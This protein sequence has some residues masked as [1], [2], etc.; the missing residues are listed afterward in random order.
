MTARALVCRILP[1]IAITTASLAAAAPTLTGTWVPDRAASTQSKELKQT[2][3]PGAPPAQG[4]QDRLP[5]LRIRHDEPRVRIEFLGDDGSVI[6]TTELTTDGAENVNTR[7]GGALTHKSRT[8]WDGTILRTTWKIE[9]NGQ[10]VIAGTDE[11][12]LASPDTLVMTTTT[13]DAK[14]RSRSVIVYRRRQL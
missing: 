5:A 7:A 11:H 12:E 3:A 10:T 2:P 6:S 4:I 13:E 14:S 1:A 8:G 9:R